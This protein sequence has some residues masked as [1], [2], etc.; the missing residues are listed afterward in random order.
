MNPD[1]WKGWNDSHKHTKAAAIEQFIK[2]ME[3]L[4]EVKGIGPVIL[5]RIKKHVQEGKFDG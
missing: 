5:E 4:Q 1:Y 2:R 3:T